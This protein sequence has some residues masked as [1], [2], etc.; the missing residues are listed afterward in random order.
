M[1]SPS[2]SV[3]KWIFVEKAPAKFTDGRLT[4]AKKEKQELADAHIRGI[5]AP[6][7]GYKREW[8][9]KQKGLYNRI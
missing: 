5:A 4:V 2:L 8:D 1:G 3:F 6:A 7:K 9:A